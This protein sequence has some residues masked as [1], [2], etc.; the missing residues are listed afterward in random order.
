MN[1]ILVTEKIYG[2]LKDKRSKV[3]KSFKQSTK[4][5]GVILSG[6]YY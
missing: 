6:N 2:Q 1:Q 4:N 3:I 5:F